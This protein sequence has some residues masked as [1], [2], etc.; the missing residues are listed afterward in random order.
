MCRLRGGA[1]VVVGHSRPKPK[2]KYVFLR[3]RFRIFVSGSE[4]RK[5]PG[6]LCWLLVSHNKHAVWLQHVQNMFKGMQWIIGYATSFGYKY[7][8]VFKRQFVFKLPFLN[9]RLVTGL[10]LLTTI[11]GSFNLHC[12]P[13][14]ITKK[15]F[16]G[17]LFTKIY[18][19]YCEVNQMTIWWM[20]QGRDVLE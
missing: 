8:G 5:A 20:I 11:S 16:L 2:T 10:G 12:N 17:N 3:Y 1:E 7:K 15:T 19:H 9:W 14:W 4:F 6:R 18:I 13:P